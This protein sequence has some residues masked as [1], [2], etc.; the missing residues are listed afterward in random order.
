MASRVVRNKKTMSKTLTF[1]CVILCLF[2]VLSTAELQRFQ[3][4][5]KEDGSLSLLVVGDWGR[6]GSYNQSQVALK[7]GIIGEKLDID[8]VIS[9]GD[10]FYD[11]G[12]TGVD[13]SAFD[14][15]FTKIYTAPSLQKQWYNVLGNHDYRG[16]VEAQMSP[17]LKKL[18]SRWLCLRSFILDTE[19]AEFF[20]VDTTPFVD[21]YFTNP[22]DHVYDWRG[23]LPRKAYLSNL[24]KDVDSALKKS[25]AKWKFVVAHHTI[26]SAGFHGITREI[27]DQLLPI[28]EAN[29]VD[30]YVNGHDHLLQHISSLHSPIQFLTSGGA[31]KAW[32]GDVNWW[33]PKE[34]KFFYDG[35]GFMSMQITPTQL[36]I[37][38][39][40]VFGQVLHKWGTSKKL[41]SAF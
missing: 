11:N 1:S 19:I 36:D 22:K 40:D 41:Y 31:S 14:D 26:K 13:D 12:L 20:F 15:S 3:H 16:D 17:V 21:S 39:Y 23:I 30:L 33:D 9:T 10:N 6:R 34:M 7:M 37:A 25:T 27:V 38:F 29:N 28:L 24:L 2:W 8:F 18:D 5:A 35:Q 4:G 32:R